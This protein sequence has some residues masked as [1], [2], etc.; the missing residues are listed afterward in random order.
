MSVG[1]DHP[2]NAMGNAIPTS[3]SRTL[4]TVGGLQ[5]S[6]CAAVGVSRGNQDV[7]S[8]EDSPHL[9]RTLMP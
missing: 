7:N 9:D 6:F 5:A 2:Q 8:Q 4:G 1:R 3:P